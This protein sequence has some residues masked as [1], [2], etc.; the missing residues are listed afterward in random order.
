MAVFLLAHEG[1]SL[2]QLKNVVRYNSINKKGLNS[3]LNPRLIGVQSNCGYCLNV[4]DKNEYNQLV[5]NFMLTVE[6]NSQLSTNSRQ[7]Y[8]YE[9]SVI[10]FSVYDDK[11]LGLKK[12]TELALE[13][14]KKYDPNFEDMP[15]MIWPQIDSQKLHFHILRG[16]FDDSGKYH[17]QS[18]SDTKMGNSAQKIEKKYALTYTGKNDPNNYIWKTDKKGKKKKIYF[19]QG[20]KNNDKIAKN[21]A[22]DLKIK[23]DDKGNIEYFNKLTNKKIG[24]ENKI[25]SLTLKK[26]TIKEKLNKKIKEINA[27]NKKLAKRVKYSIWQ[28]HF[29]NYSK[30]DLFERSEKITINNINKIDL[31]KS[32]KNQF[33]RINTEE[34]KI[35][36]SINSKSNKLDHCKS[37][38]KND[39][40]VLD[41]HKTHNEKINDI[42]NIINNAYRNSESSEMFIKEINKNG[43]EACI[44]IRKN[45]Q[46]GIS[47][48]HANSDISIAAG[49][50]NSHLT[51]GKIK[52]ND[53]HLFD[54]LIGKES[55]KKIVLPQDHHSNLD[56]NFD[57]KKINKNYKQKINFDGSISIF[58]HKKDAVKYPY[59]HNI[60]VSSD[61]K[62]IS[63]GQ[64]INDHDLQLAYD[65]A[66]DN[67]WKNGVSEDKD[68]V[69]SLMM[70][71]YQKDKD[72]LFFF[73]TKE[74]TLKVTELEEII[75]NDLLSKDNLIKLYDNNLVVENDREALRVFVI[76]QLKN[77]NED[78][79]IINKLLDQNIKLKDVLDPENN[80]RKKILSE[81]KEKEEQAKKET[82]KLQKTSH[83][84]TKSRSSTVNRPKLKPYD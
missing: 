80:I 48:H 36:D 52:K 23:I 31:K 68:L 69:K 70:L 5:S 49:K 11:K 38:M 44:N 2:R 47:F 14:A 57:I 42:K 16:Y 40:S 20:N 74:S 84:A 66:K 78:L 77:H 30:I 27:V 8:L 62:T 75:G 39:K 4:D 63:F 26:K 25:N 21:K 32:V 72:D 83:T 33:S 7:K 56:L 3:D 76:N 29:S 51:F 17:R 71:S 9:H 54:L 46:G 22:I 61:Y 34:K 55:Q 67:A 79:T 28:K 6:A 43:I 50:V 10:S 73:K 19:P 64:R 18:Y 45:G 24:Y 65:F 53:P 1:K 13:T 58:F 15:Y 35:Q 81:H 82:I 60:K 59:N 41:L 12:A 37:E